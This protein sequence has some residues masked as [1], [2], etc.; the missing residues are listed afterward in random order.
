MCGILGVVGPQSGDC[1]GAF[2]VA[3]ELLAHRGP[4][5]RGAYSSPGALLGHRRLS[6]I[7][8]SSAG[9]QPMTDSESG[10]VIVLNGEIYNYVEIREELQ[11]EGPSF[12]TQ[13]DTEVLL[14]A[15]LRWDVTCLPRLNG[16]FAFAVWFPRSGRLLLARDRFGV[17]P[18]YYTE[19]ADSVAFASEPKALLVLYPELR[20]ANRPALYDFLAQGRLYASNES[21]YRG[22][23]LV[24][25]AHWM[26]YRINRPTLVRQR[27]WWYPTST[28]PLRAPQEEA[29]DFSSLLDDAVRLRLRS[30]VPVGVSLSGGLDSTAVLAS[31]VRSASRAPVCFTSVYSDQLRGEAQWA[32]AATAPYG[33]APIEVEAPLSDWIETLRTVCWH[34]DGPGSSPA[35]FP[36]WNLVKE[37]RRRGVRVLLEGQ[38]ADEEL[39]GYPQYAALR[40]LGDLSAT[41]RRPSPGAIVALALEAKRF[42]GTFTASWFAL[43]LLRE[44][45]PGLIGLNRRSFGAAS[46]LRREF[47]VEMSEVGLNSIGGRSPRGSQPITEQLLVDHSCEILPGLLHYG[48]AVSMAHGIEARQPFLDYRLVEWLF[49]RPDSIKIVGGESKWLVRQ[50]LRRAGHP[51]IANRPDKLGYPTPSDEWLVKNDAALPREFLLAPQARTREFCEPRKVERLIH[52]AIAG[53]HGAGHHLYRLLST[54]IWLRECV[55][56]APVSHS[57][58]AVRP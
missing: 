41:L 58:G 15:I 31:S 52:R 50:Y 2:E 29:E 18:L 16:M 9:R 12:R 6:I 40:F 20:L 14:R 3:L 35:V 37:A 43:W 44:K 1:V 27:F 36:L 42:A 49:A 56:G 38:G 51:E 25:P 54:E 23:H 48:D 13:T 11:R 8:L 57:T 30:D 24:P 4:D 5:D 34:M 26:E 33:S 7:D 28:V 17:K 53:R 19:R 55:D 21:F 45:F 32:R 39:G 47:V 46:T 22:I 10:A